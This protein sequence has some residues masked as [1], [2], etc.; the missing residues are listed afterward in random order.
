MLVG[1]STVW[2][3]LTVTPIG[4]DLGIVKDGLGVKSQGD[5]NSGPCGQAEADDGEGIAIALGSALSGYLIQAIDVDL[6]L[7]FNAEVE[8]TYRHDGQ[9]VA[10]D[11]FDGMGS[12]DG[13]DSAD[14]DNY[15]YNS[16]EEGIDAF[17]DE[18]VFMATTGAFSL[19][20]GV[21]GT[22]AAGAGAG[23]A[24]DHEGG[25]TAVVA[26]ADVGATSFLAD[27]VELVRRDEV[28]D[29]LEAF[30]TG[31]LGLEPGRLA[32]AGRSLA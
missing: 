18:V 32:F 25:G 23:V 16:E 11:T 10:S 13:P 20:A 17:F 3:L 6:E 28:A 2:M 21:D 30:A 14:L 15:R 1:D 26:L 22:E 8:I 4:G 31:K 9:F 5:G 27:G 7:K 24:E 12:D 19:E 29:H